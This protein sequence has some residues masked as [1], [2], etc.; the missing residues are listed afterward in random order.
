VLCIK[1]A[2][3]NGDNETFTGVEGFLPSCSRWVFN[4]IFGTALP[5]LLPERTMLSNR[6]LL[7][8]GDVNEYEAFVQAQATDDG[9]N[10]KEFQLAFASFGKLSW[11]FSALAKR[12][13]KEK[14]ILRL[15]WSG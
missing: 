13:D 15:L 2:A 9:A 10:W 7:T 1:L 5:G 3:I 11:T 6:L 14:T 4:W 12:I 8:D